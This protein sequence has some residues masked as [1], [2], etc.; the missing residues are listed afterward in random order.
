MT[1]ELRES[2][3]RIGAD[4]PGVSVSRERLSTLLWICAAACLMFG[5]LQVQQAQPGLLAAGNLSL[6]AAFVLLRFWALAPAG[7]ARVGIAVSLLAGLG[8][9]GTAWNGMFTGGLYAVS[10]WFFACMPV[11]VALVLGV[12]AAILWAVFG[13]LIIVVAWVMTVRDLLPAAPA[14]PA[15]MV[16]TSQLLLLFILTGYAVVARRSND[17]H[18]EAVAEAHLALL[19]SLA[20]AEEARREA[21]AANQAKSTFLQMMSHEIRTPL[22]G[23]IGLNNLLLDL[24]LEPRAREYAELARQSGEALL[25]LINDFLDFSRI[26][27]AQLEVQKRPFSPA[28]LLNEIIAFIE[29]GAN[30][31]GLQVA[32]QVDAPAWLLGDPDRL[33]QILLNLLGNAVKFTEHGRIELICRP[34]PGAEPQRLRFEVADTGLGIPREL[35]DRLFE[36]FV[37]AETGTSRRF[38]GTGLGLTIC[39]SLVTLM[40]GEIG[41]DSEPGQGSRFWFEL[42]VEQ[43]QAP[44]V[45]TDSDKKDNPGIKVRARVLL[46]E[47]NPVN[48]VVASRML[49][50]VGASVDVVED[51]EQALAALARYDYDMLL[52]DCHMPRLDGYATAERIRAAK[53]SKKRLPIIAIT[54]S[55]MT[56]DRERCLA[57]GMDDYITKPIRA[58]E[59]R[60]VFERWL[61]QTSKPPA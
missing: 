5:L 46:A 28:Q 19:Q 17:R 6:A 25:S 44:V 3:W 38:G 14:L 54:A 10:F 16:A 23:V 60:R 22:N 43:T 11:V 36:P 58:E 37:Q 33:R 61:E 4:K 12:R 2:L 40:G 39:H 59:L 41:F 57:A 48:Q 45:E 31:K 35:G 20:Q 42:P 50:R 1:T 26:E 24:P 51:G 55:A 27:A 52:L 15:A 47:D 34:V 56:G 18:L 13:G 32:A 49:E 21:D 8:V 29:P 30:Q 7:D 53:Q 9:L